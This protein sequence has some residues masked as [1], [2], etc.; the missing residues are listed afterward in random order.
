MYSSGI[1]NIKILKVTMSKTIK[2][3]IEPFEYKMTLQDDVLQIVAKHVDECLVWSTIIEDMLVDPESVRRD[4]KEK[5]FIVNL[6]PDEIFD[7]FDCHVKSTLDNNTKILFPHMYKTETDHICI[8]IDFKISFG[9]QRTDTKWIILDPEI[10]PKDVINFQKLEHVKSNML[11]KINETNTKIDNINTQIE[12]KLVN[13][14]N[15]LTGYV[16]QEYDALVEQIKTVKTELIDSISKS[17]DEK[18]QVKI[19]TELDELENL[20]TQKYTVVVTN[21]ITSLRNFML[22]EFSKYQPKLTTELTNLQ[23]TVTQQCDAKYHPKITNEL[24][25]LQNDIITL[26]DT[27]YAPKAV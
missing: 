17:C 16:D 25:T 8:T 23:T 18:F 15:T 9:K 1:Y 2:F 14:E 20:I 3:V 7:I 10:I 24:T 22:Q 27:K 21:E 26:C 5:K 11:N 13:L 6:V 19:T 4:N 12:D